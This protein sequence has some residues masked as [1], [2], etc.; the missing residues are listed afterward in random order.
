MV[1]VGVGAVIVILVIPLLMVT[2]CPVIVAMEVVNSM[3]VNV[4]VDAVTVVVVFTG[5]E[6]V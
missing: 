5:S 4:V 1:F 3:S 6:A 2:S